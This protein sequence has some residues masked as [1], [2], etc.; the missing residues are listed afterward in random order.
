[1]SPRLVRLAVV[2]VL[3]VVEVAMFMTADWF[4][5]RGR[6]AIAALAYTVFAIVGIALLALFAQ[7][8][9]R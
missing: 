9:Q 3:L 6:G 8:S 4:A 7:S 5:G 2:I 1:M